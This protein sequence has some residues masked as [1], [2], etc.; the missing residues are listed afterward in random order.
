LGLGLY[1]E[2]HTEGAF[3]TRVIEES[4]ARRAGLSAGDEIQVVQG[5]QVPTMEEGKLQSLINAN[6]S[7]GI[8]M[9]V[10]RGEGPARSIK[11]RDGAVYPVV[12]E[13]VAID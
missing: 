9:T 7:V 2:L 1:Y 10:K 5:Q 12:G 4:P 11:L 8:D 3:V 13:P 6:A